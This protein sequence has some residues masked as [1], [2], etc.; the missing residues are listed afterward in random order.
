VE[1]RRI[2]VL[3]DMLELGDESAR[4]HHRVGQAAA[5]ADILVAIGED[6]AVLAQG[7][8]EAGMPDERVVLLSATLDDADSFT[9]ARES[10]ETFLRDTLHP[11]DAIL[12]K[13]SNG[14]GL[15]PIANLL[16]DD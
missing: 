8:R 16:T 11:T 5:S 10:L 6:A 2:A 7:A 4:D 14:L 15:G 9:A 13:A 3:G 1:G 12:L